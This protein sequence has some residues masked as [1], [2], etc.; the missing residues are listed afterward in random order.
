M[1]QQF[2]EVDVGKQYVIKF[3]IYFEK[4]GNFSKHWLTIFHMTADGTD[5]SRLP[6]LFLSKEKKL[7]VGVD[8]N[9]V[10]NNHKATGVIDEGKWYTVEMSQRLTDGKVEFDLNPNST[11]PSVS[12]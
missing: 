10:K 12:L 1:N 7:Y 2:G 4:M 3:D 11:F 8:M 9:G 6:A 5:A